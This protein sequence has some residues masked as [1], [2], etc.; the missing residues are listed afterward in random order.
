MRPPQDQLWLESNR[1]RSSQPDWSGR[2]DGFD[3]SVAAP[4]ASTGA[5]R[6]CV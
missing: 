2:D 4:N 3:T 6:H 5:G 1:E